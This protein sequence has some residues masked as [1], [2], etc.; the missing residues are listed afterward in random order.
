MTIKPLTGCVLVQLA[1]PDRTSAG[2]I[3]IPDVTLSPEEI[4]QR[5]HSPAPP[6]AD[7]AIVVAIGP[8]PKLPNGMAL[9]PPFGIGAR[10]LVRHTAGIE[11]H[12]DIGER[13]KMMT[14]EDVLAVL[15]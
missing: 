4:Q 15:S 7:E 10:V 13:F 9:L 5:N 11:M 1:A 12:Q 6:P 8:W 14:S 2:G 3:A